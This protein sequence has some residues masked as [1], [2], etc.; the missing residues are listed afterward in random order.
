M[1]EVMLMLSGAVVAFVEWI[2]SVLLQTAVFTSLTQQ[3]QTMI[4]QLIAFVAG[5]VAAFAANI[6]VLT[7][8]PAFATAPTWVGVIIT[9]LIAS[10]GSSGIHAVLAL[11]GY[12][13]GVTAEAQSAPPKP[14]AEG[15]AAHVVKAD[16]APFM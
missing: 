3:T 15:V 10:T 11:I 7:V 1:L 8:F 13:P 5:C 14:Q 16:Y 4:L 9:G 2:K 12:R 6:N